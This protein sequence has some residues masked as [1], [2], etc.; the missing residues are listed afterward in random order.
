MKLNNI[1]LSFF[2][3]VLILL[4]CFLSFETSATALNS[5]RNT[6]SAVN[7][8]STQS[9]VACHLFETNKDQLI[10]S[11]NLDFSTTINN[12][13]SYIDPSDM[14][15]GCMLSHSNEKWILLQ[16]TSGSSLQFQFE[17]SGGEDIDAAIWGPVHPDSLDFICQSL[18]KF[19][20]DC[21]YS[22]GLPLLTIPQAQAG[23]FYIVMISNSSNLESTVHLSQPTGGAVKFAYL[24]PGNI[25]LNVPLENS[26]K[27]SASKEVLISANLNNA[28]HVEALSGNTVVL[29]PGFSTGENVVFEANIKECTLTQTPY[30][31][32]TSTLVPCQEFS[33]HGPHT[34]HLY[35]NTYSNE[36]VGTVFSEDQPEYSPDYINWYKMDKV[37]KDDASDRYLWAYRHPFTSDA[38]VYLRSREGCQAYADVR[39]TRPYSY[40]GEE[41]TPLP[42][43]AP[44]DSFA[45]VD[46]P[47]FVST[48][49]TTWQSTYDI[50][51]VYLKPGLTN[52]GYRI[53]GGG[54]RYN[55][56]DISIWEE[57]NQRYVDVTRIN[58]FTAPKDFVIDFTQDAGQ[59]ID[60]YVVTRNNAGGHFSVTSTF[61]RVADGSVTVHTFQG[62]INV[63]MQLGDVVSSPHFGNCF[64]LGYRDTGD[65]I[66]PL[67]SPKGEY[68][69]DDHL[70]VRVR[71]LQ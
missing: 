12:S 25:T 45:N 51:V 22:A 33:N 53:N 68:V 42:A 69:L 46:S 30:Q 57:F 26:Q 41:D 23:Y 59:T 27:Q 36:L 63:P 29:L 44:I 32:T 37:G 19:P 43:L 55:V 67:T 24:C 34:P 15:T 66:Y 48:T 13:V 18:K 10:F 11:D 14:E 58:G 70:L 20:L 61:T 21:E 9:A 2:K 64:R 65:Y 47:F 50:F 8:D 17:T 60:R 39:L 16:V 35:A 62:D 52:L 28:S 38:L 49:L 40:Q 7:I 3:I 54:W 1:F 31:D 4:A 56:E 71:S 6:V 5:V